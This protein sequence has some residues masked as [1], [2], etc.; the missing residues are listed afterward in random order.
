MEYL[1]N[2]CQKRFSERRQRCIGPPRILFKI[3]SRTSIPVLRRVTRQHAQHPTLKTS[4]VPH[5]TY[6]VHTTHGTRAHDAFVLNF[7]TFVSSCRFQ[8]CPVPYKMKNCSTFRSN[9]AFGKSHIG[10][11]STDGRIEII[12]ILPHSMGSSLTRYT[13]G[14]RVHTLLLPTAPRSES[15]RGDSDDI[16]LRAILISFPAT[17]E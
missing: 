12:D 16:G 5:H 8:I 6:R 9:R 4:C 10:I 2:L 7:E 17:S 3:R 11:G 14:I 13:I 1:D 15:S